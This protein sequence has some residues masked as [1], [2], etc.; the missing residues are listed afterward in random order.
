MCLYGMS[1]VLRFNRVLF[2][3]SLKTGQKVG[4]EGCVP[5]FDSELAPRGNDVLPG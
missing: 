4:K 2:F 3:C 1:G 5:P